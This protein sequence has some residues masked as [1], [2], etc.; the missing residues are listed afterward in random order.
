D[1]AANKRV[2][3]FQ[4]RC[5]LNTGLVVV[6]NIGSNLHMEYLAIGDTV[7]LAARMQSA[8]EPGTVLVADPTARRIK[9][10]FDLESR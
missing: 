7:N 3:H 4:M 9:H 8:A 1:L 10:A 2:D 5:G 6:G